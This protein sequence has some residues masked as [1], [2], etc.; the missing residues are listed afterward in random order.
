MKRALTTGS[1]RPA[2]A[3]QVWVVWLELGGPLLRS[4]EPERYVATN[5]P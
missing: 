3:A 5:E 1:R 2:K 4:P